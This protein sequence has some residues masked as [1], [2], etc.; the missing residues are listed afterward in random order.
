MAYSLLGL[1]DINMPLLY[2]E[3]DRAFLRHQEHTSANPTDHS[4]FAWVLNIGS[5]E[6]NENHSRSH[7]SNFAR[8]PA[9]FSE[10]RYLE[11]EVI[12]HPDGWAQTNRGFHAVFLTIPIAV[13]KQRFDV[14]GY[15]DDKDY[16][17]ILNYC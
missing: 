14:P 15:R 1:F 6:A 17:I 3:V 7:R 12:V 16:P 2:G 10:C 5:A 13:M 11:E 8:S 4:I 9:D